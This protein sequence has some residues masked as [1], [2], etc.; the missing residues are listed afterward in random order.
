VGSGG[1]FE[2]SPVL[3]HAFAEEVSRFAD[4]AQAALFLRDAAGG[5]AMRAG[6]LAGTDPAYAEDDPAFALMR[7]ERRPI[8]TAQARGTLPGVLALPMLDQG[9]LLGFVLLDRKPGGADYRP[10]EVELL[11]WATHQIGLDLQAIR[12]R[13]LE[14]AIAELVATNLA[15]SADRDRL[16]H[17]LQNLRPLRDIA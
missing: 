8:E 13:D 5:Y 15:I 7:A 6:S 9:T 12:A 4:G 17:I 10:D 2:Q 16:S 3:C 11:G 14:A 1:H